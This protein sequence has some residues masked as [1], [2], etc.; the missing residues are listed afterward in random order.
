MLYTMT[1][2]TK[3]EMKLLETICQIIFDKNGFNILTLDVREI[4]TMTDFFIIAEGNV[5]KHVQ[6]IAKAICKHLEQEDLGPYH[7]EGYQEGDWIVLD[8][9]Y[10]VIHLF[11]GELR[12]HYALEELWNKADIVDVPIQTLTRAF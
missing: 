6:A 3:K 1:K 11:T 5:D 7:I 12:S 8:A 9:L 2:P 4:S 10:V